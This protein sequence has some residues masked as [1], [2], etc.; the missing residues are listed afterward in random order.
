LKKDEFDVERETNL[1]AVVSSLKYVS[2]TSAKDLV[3][4]NLGIE[5]YSKIRLTKDFLGCASIK[6]YISLKIK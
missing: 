3:S 4:Y 2:P 6:Y 5:L 1:A